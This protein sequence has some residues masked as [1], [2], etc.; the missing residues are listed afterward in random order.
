MP[1]A[2]FCWEVLD[3]DAITGAIIQGLERA[4][5]LENS[6]EKSPNQGEITTISLI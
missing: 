2:L 6:V 4:F 5:S 3:I 1:K